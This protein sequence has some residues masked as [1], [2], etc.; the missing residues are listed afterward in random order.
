MGDPSERF[1][2]SV[3]PCRLRRF[4]YSNTQQIVTRIPMRHET[5]NR[6]AKELAMSAGAM[7]FALGLAI[8]ILW[9]SLHVIF[10]LK[11]HGVIWYGVLFG[12]AVPLVLGTAVWRLI[13]LIKALAA[14]DEQ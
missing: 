14:R 1:K 12:I 2:R 10:A 4:W 11:W 7:L 9:L 8:A 6:F 3:A 5:F 13:R